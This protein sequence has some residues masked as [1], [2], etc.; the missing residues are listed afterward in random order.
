MTQ[1][2]VLH[3]F[4]SIIEYEKTKKSLFVESRHVYIFDSKATNHLWMSR[5]LIFCFIF[6]S[7][8]RD[9]WPKIENF[10]SSPGK[11]NK[12][13]SNNQVIKLNWLHEK[14]FFSNDCGRLCRHFHGMEK[15]VGEQKSNKFDFELYVFNFTAIHPTWIHVECRLILFFKCIG[16]GLC[17]MNG[18]LVKNFIDLN[19]RIAFKIHWKFKRIMKKTIHI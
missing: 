11:I 7:T 15:K 9:V 14:L 12:F 10:L 16:W 8:P 4:F 17:D 2:K 3:R 1:R 6:S 18:F 5:G 13:C 19:N